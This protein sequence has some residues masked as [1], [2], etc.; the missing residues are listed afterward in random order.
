MFFTHTPRQ[1]YCFRFLQRG[2]TLELLSKVVFGCQTEKGG[3]TCWLPH[4]A[5]LI[6]PNAGPER[7]ATH[8]TDYDERG[9][10]SSG[11][12]PDHPSGSGRSSDR[13]NWAQLPRSG[14]WPQSLGLAGSG[15]RSEDASGGLGERGRSLSARVP[16]TFF[17]ERWVAEQREEAGELLHC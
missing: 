11:C 1:V 7:Y 14:S 6:S 3:V 2:V 8:A 10:P 12:Q 15:R 4:S 16:Q 17:F 9:G 13:A 5:V